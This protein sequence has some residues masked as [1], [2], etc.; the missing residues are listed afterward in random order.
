MS[1]AALN[2]WIVRACCVRIR[3]ELVCKKYGRQS[4]PEIACCL[5]VLPTA[6][7][8][9]PPVPMSVTLTILRLLKFV[10]LK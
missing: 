7:G 2:G 9:L 8:V 4:Q 10:G 3:R 6:H 5:T 1:P